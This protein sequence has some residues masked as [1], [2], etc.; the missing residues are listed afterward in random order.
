M[1]WKYNDILPMVIFYKSIIQVLSFIVSPSVVDEAKTLFST[2]K[3]SVV[4]VFIH[5]NIAFLNGYLHSVKIKPTFY[6]FS[7]YLLLQKSFIR[8]K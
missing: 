5:V 8:F 3:Y 1:T 7:C 2:M 4:F 6:Q